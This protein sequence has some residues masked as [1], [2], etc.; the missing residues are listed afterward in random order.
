MIKCIII[1]AILLEKRAESVTNMAIKNIIL[2]IGNVLGHFCWERVFT[3][4]LDLHGEDFDR[5][6]KATVFSP[7]WIEL[8]RGVMPYDDI[9]KACISISP[10]DEDAI[11][12]FFS[13]FGD[14]VDEYEYSV[15]WIKGLKD[16]GYK[17]YLLSNFGEV[18]FTKCRKNGN[19]SFVDLADGAMIS[20]KIKMVKPDRDIYECF[21][22][23]FSLKPEEC[24]FFDDSLDNV[25]AARM[26]GINAEQFVGYDKAQED[27]DKWVK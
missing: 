11:R 19:L 21:L 9:L 10:R 18:A 22:E 14:I 13:H 12:K 26:V 25:K 24:L 27:L 4:L 23:T 6:A 20:Y 2:D 8:D 1:E 16:R 7:H 3:D 15:P 5:V 17:V